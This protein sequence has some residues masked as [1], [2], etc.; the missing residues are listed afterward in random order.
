MDMVSWTSWKGQ[1]L[2]VQPA[3]T[4]GAKESTGDFWEAAATVLTAGT[5][6]RS[7]ESASNAMISPE[8]NF[9]TYTSDSVYIC[10]FGVGL[11]ESIFKDNEQIVYLSSHFKP[12]KRRF[13]QFHMFLAAKP[14]LLASRGSME[15][16]STR[17]RRLF[18]H[19]DMF[20]LEPC[21]NRESTPQKSARAR[22][23]ASAKLSSSSVQTTS[24]L[25]DALMS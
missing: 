13:A 24:T 19:L 11:P 21:L 14:I 20:A 4:L 12:K 2:E 7:A 10:V 15:G 22:Y 25:P 8:L 18:G 5:S 17:A 6:T 23:S 16:A 3:M 9:R 1:G